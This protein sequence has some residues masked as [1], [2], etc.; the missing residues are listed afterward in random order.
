MRRSYIDLPKRLPGPRK[1]RLRARLLPVAIALP[2]VIVLWLTIG[3]PMLAVLSR[4]DAGS[5][6]AREIL[7][8]TSTQSAAPSHRPRTEAT[9]ELTTVGRSVV[10]PASPGDTTRELVDST[11]NQQP[12][13][14]PAAPAL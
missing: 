3:L 9:T 12:A 10:W 5:R 1:A 7:F 4:A 8:G 2:L 14:P 6:H 11:R 13:K